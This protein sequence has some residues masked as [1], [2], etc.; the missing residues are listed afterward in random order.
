MLNNDICQRQSI[1]LKIDEK[2]ENKRKNMRFRFQKLIAEGVRFS[3]TLDE[4]TSEAQCRYVGITLHFVELNEMV[5]A[6]QSMIPYNNIFLLVPR[7]GSL[8]STSVSLK[9]TN[10]H[11]LTLTRRSAKRL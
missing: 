8:T 4:W 1:A 2:A 6:Y 3:A 11:C 10:A 9:P 7:K 5:P